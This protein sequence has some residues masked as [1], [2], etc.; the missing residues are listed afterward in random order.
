MVSLPRRPTSTSSP[1]R[2]PQISCKCNIFP[3]FQNP[4]SLPKPLDYKFFEYNTSVGK[5]EVYTDLREVTNRFRLKPGTYCIVPTT[6]EAAEEGAFLIRV[7]TE[8]KHNMM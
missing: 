3:Q 2:E 5:S 8:T 1:P 6:L 4:K 7:F